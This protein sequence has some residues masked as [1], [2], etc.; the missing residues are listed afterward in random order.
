[1]ITRR[2]LLT[3]PILAG[4]SV[5][6][7]LIL[8]LVPGNP[9]S[10]ILGA[11]ATPSMI[12]QVNRD[13]GLNRP[14]WTQFASWIGNLLHGNLGNDYITNQSIN[15]EMAARLPVTLELAGVAFVL[16]AVVAIPAGVLSAVFPGSWL[17]RFV[18]GF[19]VLTIA[20][21]DFVFGIL[22]ILLF[23]L[24]LGM[25][26][27]SGYIQASRG[28][29][30]N[31]HSL[32]L[33]AA[34]LALGLGGVLARTSRSAM[35]E[36]L[37]TDYIRLARAHGM[38]SSAVI[39]LYGLRNAAIPIVT[40]AGMQVGYLLGGTVVVEQLFAIPGVG[41][42]VVQA[43]L[44]RNYPVVQTCVLIFVVMFILVNLVSDL[45]YAALNP[46]LRRVPA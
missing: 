34:A 46:R 21:P 40:V 43:M 41:Q 20:V 2:L 6:I 19:S 5:I 26:P 38:S 30:Q 37:D 22:G 28:L 32:I 1:M 36:V 9:A 35:L 42:L 24:T 44:S 3:V 25:V 16:A 8:R 23:A 39:F 11:N 18:R 7:F 13:L 33:P 14:I 12:D 45:L 4:T 15:A 31:L 17:D 10:A 27:S 29:G